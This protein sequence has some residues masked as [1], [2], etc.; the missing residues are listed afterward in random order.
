[1]FRDPSDLGETRTKD[2]PDS[3]V[4]IKNAQMFLKKWEDVKSLNGNPILTEQAVRE[5]Y[6]IMEHMKKGCLSG[7]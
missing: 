4:L 1:M 3:E 6:K 7:M 5:V 2:T